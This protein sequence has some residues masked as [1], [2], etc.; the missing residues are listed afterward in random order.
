MSRFKDA[1]PILA[2]AERWKH[3]CLLGE[4][5]LF[6]ERPLWTGPIVQEVRKVHA[7]AESRDE[8]VGLLERSSSEAKCLRSEMVW[9][10]RLIQHRSSK[11]PAKKREEIGYWWKR[12]GVA[13]EE[14]H[15]LLSDTLLGAGVVNTGHGYNIKVWTEIRFFADAMAKWSSAGP[16][17]P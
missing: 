10:Y 9:V 17:K 6:A 12:S 3:R 13:F 7:E 4:K 16:K 2:A 11:G 14:D 5:S 1:E 15:E 8:V